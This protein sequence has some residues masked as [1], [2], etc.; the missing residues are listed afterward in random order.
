MTDTPREKYESQQRRL[1]GNDERTGHIEAGRVTEEEAERIQELCDAFDGEKLD[2]KHHLEKKEAFEKD[3]DRSYSTLW[4]WMYRLARNSRDMKNIDGPDTL[5]EADAEFINDLM[6]RYHAG[7][8]PRCGGLS[9]GTIQTYQFSLRNFYRYH[10][11]LGVDPQHIATYNN[12]ADASVDP[13]DMLTRDEIEQ[14]KD[15]ASHPMDKMVFELLLYT[16]LR[17]NA[18]RT[19][20]VKDI[21]LEQGVYQFNPTVDYGLKGADERNGKRPLLFAE[22][23][24]RNWINNYHPGRHRDDF[25][26]CYL[27]TKKPQYN[28]VDPKNPVANHVM[29]YTLNKLREKVGVEKPMKPHAMRHNF[30]TICK[31]DYGMD[32]DTIKYLI[33]HAKDSRVMETTY[34]HLSDEDFLNNAQ[35][36]AGVR[37]PEETSTLTPKKCSCGATVEPTAKACPNCGMMFTPDAQGAQNRIK[38]D[39]RDTK[40]EAETLEE[41]KKLNELEQLID[42]NPELISVLESMTE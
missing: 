12:D 39:V 30:V 11:D 41:H 2:R 6:E 14:L 4:G 31:R 33:G 16:G 26:E 34:S 40:E 13:D 32:N 21:D 27:I 35:E 3:S 29:R 23:S 22:G 20:R 36:A 10:S 25:E 24:V 7:D 37:E 9:K 8:L 19:L 5:L 42:D 17:D 28:K 18:A 1:W 38:G 15:A